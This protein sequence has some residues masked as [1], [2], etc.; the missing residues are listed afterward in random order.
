MF[1]DDVRALRFI[2]KAKEAGLRIPEDIGVTGCDG[3]GLASEVAGLLTVR[4]PVER[5]CEAAAE[6]MKSFVVDHEQP[7]GV[8]HEFYAG[9]IIGG[10]TV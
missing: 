2:V 5:V 6:Y 10:D 3:L 1:A 9:S 4:M 7:D 8:I